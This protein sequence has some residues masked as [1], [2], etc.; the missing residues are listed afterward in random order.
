MIQENPNILLPIFPK[1]PDSKVLTSNDHLI[2]R[3]VGFWEQ[4]KQIWKNKFGVLPGY[5]KF[6]FQ[7]GNTSPW[8][9]MLSKLYWETTGVRS[10]K[11]K[12]LRKYFSFCCDICN[13][14]PRSF[15]C[16][17][18]VFHLKPQ[19]M[20]C[21][22]V[23][24]MLILIHGDLILHGSWPGNY[25]TRAH[26]VGIVF[27]AFCSCSQLKAEALLNVNFL[28]IPGWLLKHR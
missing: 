11:K 17:N 23:L 4:K 18:S 15:C 27:W 14:S 28:V 10:I 3:K 13:W 1:S 9:L 16:L 24:R 7:D 6:V 8:V 20:G 21:F 5:F 2:Y 22:K 12:K 26:P 19:W 25:Q